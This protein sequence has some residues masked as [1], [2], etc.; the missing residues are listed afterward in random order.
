MR[1][2]SLDDRTPDGTLV[3]VSSDGASC[4]PAASI[5]RTLQ[6]A[7]ERWPEVEPQLRE[8]AK[9]LDAGRATG[10]RAL[11]VDQL[12]APLP[13]AWQWLDGSAYPAHGAL[14]DQVLGIKPEKRDRPLM[15]QGVSNPFYG[16]RADVRMASEDHGIDFE[17]EFGVIV[18]AVPMGTDAAAAAGD[19]K[20]LVKINDWSLPALAGPEMKTGFG[21]IQAKPPCGMAP[22]AITPDELGEAWAD[23]RPGLRLRVQWNRELFGDAQG[24]V[25]SIQRMAAYPSNKLEG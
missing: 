4:A 7:I 9:A 12:A 17:G 15:Y 20:L 1:L 18:D 10:A 19:I 14:M 2:A 25:I 21:W 8:L 16:P 23:C 24:L 6:E 5:C 3:V 11:D 22:F 13:R